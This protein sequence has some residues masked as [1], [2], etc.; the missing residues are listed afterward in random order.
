LNAPAPASSYASTLELTEATA[1]A[2]WQAALDRL[3]GLTR[4]FAQGA[5]SVAIS[6]PNRLVVSFPANY[7]FQKQQCE[8]PE[9]RQKIEEALAIVVGTPV[10]LSVESSA[11]PRQE[12]Q[13]EHVRRAP[14]RQQRIAEARSYPLVS[15][16]L[17]MFDA[18]ILKVD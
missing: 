3:V 5:T 18:E 7:N 11:P 8:R 16:A 2:V 12:E 13:P 4:N 1:S 10:A 17:A 15:E 6:G 14:S 9:H